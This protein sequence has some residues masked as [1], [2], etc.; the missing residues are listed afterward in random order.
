MTQAR[1]P[2]AMAKVIR[3]MDKE[4]ILRQKVMP[5]QKPHRSE[6]VVVTPDD[7]MAAVVIRF[8]RITFDLA[9]SEANTKAKNYFNES[10]DSL[11]KNWNRLRGV[12]WLNPPYA[13]IKLWAAKC[14]AWQG[15]GSLLLLIPASVGS[16]WWAEHVD[17]RARV[18]FLSPRVTFVGHSSPYPKDLSLCVFMHTRPGYECWR[19]KD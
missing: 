13:N 11:I 10:D 16:N 7:L 17:G 19:W 1:L 5:L 12:L 9:A 8:G 4:R 14:A 6:Q 18:L 15:I 2:T 3:L